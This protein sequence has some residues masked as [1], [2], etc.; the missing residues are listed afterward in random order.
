MNYL[1]FLKNTTE[2]REWIDVPNIDRSKIR[3]MSNGKAYVA[4]TPNEM[5]DII[6]IDDIELSAQSEGMIFITYLRSEDPGKCSS[7][8]KKIEETFK[9]IENIRMF[10][11]GGSLNAGSTTI[12]DV[13]NKF[14]EFGFIDAGF[15]D[16]N[17]MNFSKDG[18][19]PWDKDIEKVRKI[20]AEDNTGDEQPGSSNYTNALAFLDSAWNKAWAYYNIDKPIEKIIEGLFPLYVDMSNISESIDKSDI[21][22]ALLFSKNNLNNLLK[23]LNFSDTNQLLT[24]LKEIEESIGVNHTPFIRGAIELLDHYIIAL[25]FTGQESDDTYKKYKEE[26]INKF[27]SFSEVYSGNNST[28]PVCQV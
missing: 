23:N 11:H 6:P 1:I 20:F 14:K 22:A 18:N 27:K 28:P 9:T 13:I 21:N 24:I 25:N 17:L 12:N 3:Q 10:H 19:F 16:K 26:F 7:E 8:Q 2:A 4:L 15:S 5:S